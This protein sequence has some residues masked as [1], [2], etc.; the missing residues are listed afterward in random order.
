MAVFV[1]EQQNHLFRAFF[2]KQ[3]LWPIQRSFHQ[4]YHGQNSFKSVNIELVML[5]LGAKYI[6]SVRSSL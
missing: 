6:L 2:Q 5:S 4:P 3:I 1:R